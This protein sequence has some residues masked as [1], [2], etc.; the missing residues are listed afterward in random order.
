MLTVYS[1]RH[2]LH[3]ARAEPFGGTVVEPFECPQRA[4]YVLARLREVG[5][6]P[7]TPPADHGLGPVLRVHDA[8]YVQFL[9]T[10]WADWTAAGFSGQ[11]T[12]SV[13]PGRTMPFRRPSSHIEARVGYYALCGE[14]G[15]VEGTWEAAYWSAQTALTALDAVL[16]GDRAAFALCRPPGHHA[17]RDQFG[18]YCFL[19]NA[20]IAAQAALDHG[21]QR[22]AVLDVDFH[23]GN[24][25]QEIFYDRSD[26][27]FL[28]LHGTPDQAYPYFMGWEDETGHGAGEGFTV[29]YPLPEGTPYSVWKQAL[30]RA[31]DRIRAYAPDLLVISLGLDT[32]EHDPISFFRLTG[33]DYRDTGALLAGVDLPTLFVME[34]GYAVDDL[35]VNTVNVLQGFETAAGD[36]P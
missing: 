12:P 32:Y 5:L 11:V 15:I 8:G 36:R 29:N 10:V 27:L 35:G 28:S 19:N 33:D 4:E 17:P 31:L 26:V 22:V 25:T 21:A 16:G 2:T 18:G 9:Q 13:W 20:A 3:H 14:T 30:E 24:G 23:H 7:V 1:D 34:G 6:G